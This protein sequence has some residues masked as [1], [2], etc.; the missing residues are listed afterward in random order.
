MLPACL[1][2]YNRLIL[3]MT[4]ESE[5]SEVE[6]Q[7]CTHCYNWTFNPDGSEVEIKDP[8]GRG[9]LPTPGDAIFTQNKTKPEGQEAGIKQVGR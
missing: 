6:V 3:E 7:A 5:T 4:D 2:C 8:V 1:V 9:Y